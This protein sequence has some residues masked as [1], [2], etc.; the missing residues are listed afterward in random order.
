MSSCP[1]HPMA[2]ISLL[3]GG[4]FGA[5]ADAEIDLTTGLMKAGAWEEVRAYCGGCHSLDL[6]T[7]QR[8]SAE[9]WQETVHTMQRSHNMAD[10]PAP[11]EA[12][13]V[14]YL[15]RHYAPQPRGHRRA[16]VPPRLMPGPRIPPVGDAER[17]GLS[18]A[19]E[20]WRR[21]DCGPTV[22]DSP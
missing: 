14:N 7:S 17:T 2:M 10:L 3:A 22:T 19:A 8:N 16:P 6:V 1:R 4:A 21:E 9:G 11:T 13:I 18:P 15:A 20:T 5:A 12:R